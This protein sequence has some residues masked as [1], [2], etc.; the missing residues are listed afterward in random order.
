MWWSRLVVAIAQLDGVNGS[1]ANY[2]KPTSLVQEATLCPLQFC[3]KN[4]DV[5]C[6]RNNY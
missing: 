5:V 3:G 4:L 6:N 1:C 2:S